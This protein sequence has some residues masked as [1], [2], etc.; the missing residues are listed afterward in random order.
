M[1]FVKTT[2]QQVYENVQ[3][4]ILM[5]W[6]TVHDEYNFI[7]DEYLI[8]GITKKLA[9]MGA[10][11][12]VFDRIGTGWINY[13]FDVEFDTK[14]YSFSPKNSLNVYALAGS[15][16]E[17]KVLRALRSQKVSYDVVELSVDEFKDFKPYVSYDVN[18]AFVKLSISSLNKTITSKYPISTESIEKYINST[19]V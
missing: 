4:N 13:V 19:K 15:K 8:E 14:T 9:E 7:I 2:S 10:V 11:K 16:T 3:Q 17:A 18:G 1:A 6:H 5:A 12:S